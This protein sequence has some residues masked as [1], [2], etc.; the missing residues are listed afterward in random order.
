MQIILRVLVLEYPYSVG[1]KVCSAR[2]TGTMLIVFYCTF[3]GDTLYI[4]RGPS[5]I[6]FL[7]IDIL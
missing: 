2:K 4:P 1:R 3:A 5:A 6:S 7:N